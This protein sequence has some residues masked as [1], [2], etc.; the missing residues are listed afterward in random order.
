MPELDILYMTRVQ[1]ER[2]F[3]ED[4][5]LR[6]KDFYI[7]DEDKMALGKPDMYVLHHFQELMRYQLMLIM[8][9]ELLI[10]SRFSLVYM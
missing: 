1:R 2:F 7:L 4:E 9:T 6:M 5:Y 10:S 8:M 3:S